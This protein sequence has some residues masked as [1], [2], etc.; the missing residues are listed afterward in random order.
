MKQDRGLEGSPLVQAA[1]GD[2]VDR[3]LS[4]HLGPEL[5]HDDAVVGEVRMEGIGGRVIHRSKVRREEGGME[6]EGEREGSPAV[7][8][9]DA[10][11]A[12]NPGEERL[13][14]GSAVSPGPSVLGSIRGN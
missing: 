6:G 7:H 1:V 10:G 9:E 2:V 13:R 11:V 5:S 14:A 4:T 8:L 12:R 3:C